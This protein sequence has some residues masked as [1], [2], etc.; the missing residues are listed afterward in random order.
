MVGYSR[1]TMG[2]ASTIQPTRGAAA[3]EPAVAAD[4]LTHAYEGLPVLDGISFSVAA[5]ERVGLVGPSGCGKST[6]LGLTAG[7]E[8]P[9]GG[10]IR[11]QPAAMMPQKDLLL[12]WRNALDNAAIALENAGAGRRRARARASELFDRFDLDRFASAR[13]WELSGG[14]RQRIA[15]I[16]TLLAETPVLLLDEPF[17]ALDAITRIELQ[18]WLLGALRTEPR[19]VILVTHDI[20]EALVVCDRL[21][22]LS[23]RPA[24]LVLELPGGL[25]RNSPELAAARERVMEALR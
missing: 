20:E 15:F 17:G 22:V 21:L 16:R 23:R 8:Q 25:P 19:T 12:P 24:R 11:S 5:G 6:L 2:S 3:G 4:R 1:L 9:T 10:T 7:L 13:T 14:M 18:D